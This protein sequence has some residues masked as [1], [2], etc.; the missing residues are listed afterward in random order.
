MKNIIITT[1]WDDG[2]ALDLKLARLLSKYG[3]RGTFYISPE[4]TNGDVL[5]P[6][7]IKQLHRMGMEVGSHTLTHPRLTRINNHDQKREI[8]ESKMLL[9]NLLNSEITSFCYP[10]GDFDNGIVSLVKSSG[11]LLARTTSSF[12]TKHT[13]DH[14]RLPTSLHFSPRTFHQLF[15]HNIKL[16]NVKGLVSWGID[17]GFETD[18]KLLA[19]KMMDM[20]KQKSGVFHL[21]GHS[22]EI[23]KYNMWGDLEYVFRMMSRADA[24]FVTNKE[25][26]A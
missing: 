6:P 16:G 14:F 15:R 4:R 19:E 7:Q 8:K 11:Y 26:I 23:E 18:P 25:L 13:D 10:K 1:S 17:Y 5:A 12:W 22:W 21:W 2:H 9:E 20:L 24:L 3:I